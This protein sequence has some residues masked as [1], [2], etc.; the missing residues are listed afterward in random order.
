MNSVVL[1]AGAGLAMGFAG[2]GHCAVMC[3]P[4][5]MLA[6]PRAAGSPR[7]A[8]HIVSYHAGRVASYA[9]LGVLLG[10]TGGFVAGRGFGRTLAVV[11]ATALAAQAI[12]QWRL[13]R[14]PAWPILTR[15]IGAAGRLMRRHTI[16]GPAAFGAL[17]GLLPCGL[18]YA[19]LTATLG[20]GDA[21]AGAA[22]MFG[23][24]VGSVP[25]LA[26]I[27]VSAKTLQA[28]ALSRVVR[29]LAPVGLAIVAL[30]LVARAFAEH[31]GHTDP[32][33]QHHAHQQ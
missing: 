31:S 19:A 8:A 12:V 9:L 21:R 25:V 4:L 1:A 7:M 14:A 26:A 32:P 11:A 22:F 6:Q 2:S 33:A 15:A 16:A 28:G 10:A 30:V 29:R 3:G 24:G 17:T 13:G 20:F 23:F 18:V 5:V 27:G